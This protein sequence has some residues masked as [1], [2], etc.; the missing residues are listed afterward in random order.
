[1]ASG[2]KAERDL[3]QTRY[4]YIEE[5]YGY[6][7]RE[8]GL[9]DCLK[10]EIMQCEIETER[11]VIVPRK[12]RVDIFNYCKQ[13]GKRVYIVSD[14]YMRQKDLEDIINNVGIV[15]YDKI[16]VSGEYDTS[17]P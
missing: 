2:V 14:M 12:A 4:P 3:S 17:K 6:I 8:I 5:I 15:G 10:A 7:A 13:L 9:D 11:Q 1:M 16:L